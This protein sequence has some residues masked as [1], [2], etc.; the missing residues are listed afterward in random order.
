LF[1]VLQVARSAQAVLLRFKTASAKNDW[2]K[3]LQHVTYS[4]STTSTVRKPHTFD[5]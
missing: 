2:M 3:R 1:A 5:V 4:S